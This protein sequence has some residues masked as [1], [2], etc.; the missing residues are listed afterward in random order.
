MWDLF[1]FYP[2]ISKSCDE[3]KMQFVS[4]EFDIFK[5][6]DSTPMQMLIIQKMWKIT[7]LNINVKH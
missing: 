5:V 1:N 4:Y 2:S 3:C 6:N 7:H